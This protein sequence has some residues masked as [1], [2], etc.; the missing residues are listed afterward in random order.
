VDVLGADDH[1]E[2]PRFEHAC[3][4]QHVERLHAHV[5]AGAA[6]I[7]V[8]HERPGAG[9]PDV[10]VQVEADRSGVELVFAD[11][12]GRDEHADAGRVDAGGVEQVLEREDADAR[13]YGSGHAG[14]HA[15]ALFDG[16]PVDRDAA[17]EGHALV[18]VN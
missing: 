11:V 2:V 17:L 4:C 18:L 8:E 15:D 12:G 9:L 13:V 14:A 5:E 1:G 6:G 10:F 7:E 3:Q 16:L